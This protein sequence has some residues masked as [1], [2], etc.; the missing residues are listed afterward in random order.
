MKQTILEHT[1][2][3]HEV[4]PYL[5]VSGGAA[6]IDFYIRVFGAQELT[7]LTYPDGRI[8]HAE[9]KLGPATLMLADEHPEYGI[10]SPQAFGG[11]GTSIHLH[12]DDVDALTARA[13]EAGATVL[14]PPTDE[15]HG[16]RQARLRDPF[17]HEWL[18]GHQI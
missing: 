6:A 12:V 17:G 8:G 10:R 1:P 11:T 18:L 7:R 13:V 5:C 16:E 15:S 3:I 2:A 9:L 14:K 4:Y